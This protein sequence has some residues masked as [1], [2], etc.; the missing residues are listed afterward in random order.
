MSLDILKI[1]LCL[2]KMKAFRIQMNTWILSV[3]YQS[4]ILSKN[5]SSVISSV[6]RHHLSLPSFTHLFFFH[7]PYCPTCYSLLC[8][9]VCYCLSSL[10]N[11]GCTWYSS[12][13]LVSSQPL[14]R[15]SVSIAPFTLPLTLT[16]FLCVSVLLSM[17][18]H[19]NFIRIPFISFSDTFFC[20][21]NTF[22]LSMSIYPF[23]FIILMV[24]NSTTTR[25]RFCLFNKFFTGLA[26]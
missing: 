1:N 3:L 9:E 5:C 21:S 23:Y 25:E 19:L 8:V 22:S 26:S 2:S 16:V 24:L 6:L 17:F 7:F 12:T 14:F 10:R 4:N 11:G 13:C 20:I 18:R 15:P